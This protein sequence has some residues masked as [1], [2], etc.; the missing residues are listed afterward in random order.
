MKKIPETGPPH[1]M[2]KQNLISENDVA[3]AMWVMLA[4]LGVIVDNID[5]E[6]NIYYTV[7]RTSTF[8]VSIRTVLPGMETHVGDSDEELA[9]ELLIA[10]ADGY[11]RDNGLEPHGGIREQGWSSEAG[12]IRTQQEQINITKEGPEILRI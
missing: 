12:Q 10:F 7:P 8:M 2:D 4:Q 5:D 9:G 6:G 3:Q 11:F 1:I